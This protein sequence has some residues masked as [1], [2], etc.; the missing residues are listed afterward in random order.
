MKIGIIITPERKRKKIIDALKESNL[1]YEFINL[2]DDNWIEYFDRDFD[3]Y[4]IFPPSFPEHWKN[5][6]LK[7]LY[8][9]KDKIINKSIP[10]IESILMYESKITMHDYLKLNKLPHIESYSFFNYKKA[11]KFSRY[12][13]LPVVIKEDT[14]S[15]ALGVKIIK[16]R[17]QL[18]YYIHKSFLINNKIRKFNSI[19]SI[20]KTIKSHLYPY[21]LFLDSDKKYLPKNLNPSGSVHIQSYLPIKNEWRIIRIGNSYFGHKK[22]EDNHGYH[23]GSLNKGWGPIKLDLL[24]L[25][26]KWSEDL[27][28]DC[29]CF[30]IFEDIHGNYFINELQ[31]IF[32]TSTEA[33]LMINGKPGRYVYKDEWIF[34]EGDFARNG[35]NNLRIELLKEKI[36]IK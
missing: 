14:G 25:V 10:S 1:E 19:K 35:C 22:L 32:G 26:K 34:E 18:I 36:Y 17:N 27:H 5:I 7:R 11:L 21:K 4:L 13:E 30:D 20:R 12:C 31:V 8:L 9:I 29:M 33:Q 16:N 23:S 6:F 15:G 3:G 24:D 28:L 2:L